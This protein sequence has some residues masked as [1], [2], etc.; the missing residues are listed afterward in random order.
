MEL[1]QF[2][3]CPQTYEKLCNG[4]LAHQINGFCSWL[5]KQGFSHSLIYKHLLNISRFND[6]LAQRS[7]QPIVTVSSLDID[8]FF[9]NYFLPCNNGAVSAN[10][11]KCIHYSVNRF[12]AFLKQ[13]NGFITKRQAPLYQPLLDAYLLWLREYKNLASGSIKLRRQYIVHLLRWLGLQATPKGLSTLT[14]YQVE[15]FFLTYDKK[16]KPETLRSLQAT[17]RTFFRFCLQKGYIEQHLDKAVPTLRTYQLASVPRAIDDDVAKRV[18][19]SIDRSTSVGKR[20]HA[21]T[22]LLYTLGLR[23]GQVAALRLDDINWVKA[24]LHIKASKN[25]KNTIL[26]LT[27]AVGDSIFS[28]LTDA[29]PNSDCPEVFLT[30]RAPYRSLCHSRAIGEIV[31]HHIINAEV[32]SPTKGTHQ[33]RHCFAGRMVLQGNSLNAIA[34]VLGHRCISSTFIYTKIDLQAL[35]QVALAWP[36][37]VFPC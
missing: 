5:D 7:A 31:R 14:S 8:S 23:A 26:P 28:Y 2:V 11:L 20:D 16:F 30:S 17:L 22:V 3:T 4:P 15:T 18:L 13:Q 29:R 19:R 6:Y 1:N 37:E 34:D 36:Q 25:G 10:H 12:I 27:K 35:K 24:Q 21:I 32:D 9:D 33:F